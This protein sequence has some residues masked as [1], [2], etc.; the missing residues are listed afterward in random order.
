MDSPEAR[1]FGS[2]G[3]DIAHGAGAEMP[4]RGLDPYKYRATLSA[5]RTTMLQIL[6]NSPSDVCGQWDAFDTVRLSAHD[7]L[8]GSPIDIVQPELGHLTRPQAETDQHCQNGDVAAAASRGSVARHKEAT[9]LV[10]VQT[11]RQS[12]Q[13]PAGSRWHGRDQR[14]FDDAIEMEEA[15]QGPKGCDRQLRRAATLSRTAG[16]RKGDN[17]SCG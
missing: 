6:G 11:F 5:G 7:D 13:S 15:E 2:I 8:A 9:D 14:A 10:R 1:P 12:D 4:M 17:V 3:H 16:H